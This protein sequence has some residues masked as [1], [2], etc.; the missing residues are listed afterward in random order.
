M[1]YRWLFQEQVGVVRLVMKFT[2]AMKNVVQTFKKHRFV[3][4]F[5]IE[6]S[7]FFR[8][9]F[10]SP[11][12]EGLSADLYSQVRFFTN[13]RISWGPKI[14]PWGSIFAKKGSQKSDFFVG[15]ASWGRPGRCMFRSWNMQRPG[16]SK[17]ALP[18]LPG[19]P[20]SIFLPKMSCQGLISEAI[21]Y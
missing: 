2:F 11:F 5:F 9:T 16:G 10:Q 3:D 7:C 18:G 8:N 20:F 19:N 6:F 14:D 1:G 12:L 13:F 4:R 21:F 15:R 17:D